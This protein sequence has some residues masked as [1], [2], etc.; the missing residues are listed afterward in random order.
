[1]PWSL[2]ALRQEHSETWLHA[3]VNNFRGPASRIALSLEY[4]S[5][6]QYGAKSQFRPIVYYE[7]RDLG[8]SPTFQ[9]QQRPFGQPTP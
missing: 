5:T 1:M 4:P 8:S 9:L 2:L 7:I 6:K 3:A